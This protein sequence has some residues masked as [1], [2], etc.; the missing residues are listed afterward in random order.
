M[1]VFGPDDRDMSPDRAD[2]PRESD[3]IA[4]NPKDVNGSGGKAY[5][6]DDY[7]AG[8]A[9]AAK[10]EQRA[11][12]AELQ[13]PS[14]A[15]SPVVARPV[16]PARPQ[17]WTPPGQMGPS[18]SELLA[19]M[20]R[21]K[22][23]ILLIAILVSA[24]IIG[25]IWTQTVLK[26]GARAELQVSPVIP[27]LVDKDRTVPFYDSFVNTQ[28]SIV[29]SPDVLNRVLEDEKVQ[30]T[31]WRQEPPQSLVEKVLGSR[32]SP[33]ERLRKS[34]SVRPRPRTEI[35]DISF[36]A[37][38]SKDAETIVNAV[39]EKYIDYE[40]KQR[41]ETWK[42]LDKT[43]ATEYDLL[44]SQIETQEKVCASLR[45]ELRTGNPEDLIGTQR[46]RLEE[47]EARRGE[48]NITIDLLKR[49]IAQLGEVDSNDADTVVADDGAEQ[50]A[51]FEDADW[52][53]LDLEV[54]TYEH[55]INSG[56]YGPNHPEMIRLTRD[57]EFTRELLQAR[58]AQLD[59]QWRRRQA[60]PEEMSPT[61]AEAVRSSP[62]AKLALLKSRL[63][64]AEY[65]KERRDEQWEQL[66]EDFD[67]LVEDAQ[68]LEEQNGE[69]RHMYAKA[70]EMRQSI[71][72][73]NMEQKIPHRIAV[74]TWA[75]SRSEPEQDRRVAYTAMALVVGLGMGSGLALLRGMRNQTIYSYADMPQAMLAPFLGHIPLVRSK[76]LPGRSLCAEIE[77]NQ[78]RLIESIRVLRTALLSR[79]AHQGCATV[80]VTSA[81]E[82]TGK[83]SFT[84]MLGKSLA[85]AGRKVLMIDTDLHKMTL[86]RR[87]GLLQRTGFVESLHS[88]DGGP[89]T[90]CSTEMP[91][92]DVLPVGQLGKKNAGPEEMANGA[93]RTCIDALLTQYDY[94][95]ILLDASPVLPVADAVIL[96]GQVDGTIMVERQNLSQRSHVM[97]ALARLNSAGGQLLGTVFVGSSDASHYGYGYGYGH[98]YHRSVSKES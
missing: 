1:N 86:S 61:A 89:P 11:P 13:H 38:S 21:Y 14:G 98:G 55:R 71:E 96:A 9:S 41:D 51:Y 67:K 27:G 56:L 70:S 2:K 47:M 53:Q 7:F 84:M 85:Q 25:L 90:V 8:G 92:L 22:W 48:L 83:S 20:L 26:Y 50:P 49:E 54:K 52:R 65:E 62:A 64:Q 39:L 30:Q 79:L 72:R 58:E 76:K 45:K 24:P 18:A 19:G 93:F 63:G 75:F 42:A 43:L 44:Q 74:L 16:L 5:S 35:I 81:D 40:A 97:S 32:I 82:G 4:R 73:R 66:K 60:D 29:R 95:I 77:R 31:R 69:L 10:D 3:P 57:L 68:R 78:V 17:R 59:E 23:T 33:M 88:K 12:T 15:V 36:A 37:R 6:F 94:D 46:V 28:V 87:F 91:N 34:L 80:L